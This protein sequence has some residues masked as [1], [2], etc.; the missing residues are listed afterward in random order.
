MKRF[1][2]SPAGAA[3]LEVLLG[4][5]ELFGG[6]EVGEG[7][8]GEGEEVFARLLCLDATA[9]VSPVVCEASDNLV[10]SITP[11]VKGG[12]SHL[13]FDHRVQVR[14]PPIQ[15]SPCRLPCVSPHQGLC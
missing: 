13:T 5:V 15:L 11:A 6:G 3:A 10:A 8:A 7:G 1:S 2:G 14:A 12:R 9:G 4:H